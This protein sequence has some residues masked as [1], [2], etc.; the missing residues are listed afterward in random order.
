MKK[1]TNYTL[2]LFLLSLLPC[3]AFAQVQLFEDFEGPTKGGYAAASVEFKSGFWYL[4][5]ALLGRQH[6]DLSIGTQSVRIRNGSI[7]MEF[8]INGAGQVRFYQ[9]NANFSGDG[10]SR[11]QLQYSTDG[12]GSWDNIG[13][14]IICADDELELTVIDVDK[15]GD[16]RFKIFKSGGPSGNRIS[17]DNFEVTKYEPEIDE[18]RL[19]AEANGSI[20]ENNATL[21]YGVLFIDDSATKTITFSNTGKD[22]LIL[23][24]ALLTGDDVFEIDGTPPLE[25][26]E[27]EAKEFSVLFSPDRKGDFTA[28]LTLE[29]NDPAAEN[30]EINFSGR[31]VPPGVP[32]DIADARSFPQETIVTVSGWVT[33]ADEFHGPVYF[34]DETAGLA[35]FYEPLMR[36]ENEGF[37]LD[38]SH[39]DSI[40]VTG[41]LTNF[42][43]LLQ[44]APVEDVMET[45]DFQVYPDANRKIE[46]K[47][48]TIEQL[49]SGAYEGQLVRL[50]SITVEEG[51]AFEGETNYDISDGINESEL[52]VSVFT[53]IPG[54]NI[55]GQPIHLVGIAS[56]FQDFHQILP[57]SRADLIQTADAP[58]ITSASPYETAATATTISFAWETDVPGT[59][60]IC[61]GETEQLELGCKED[62][63]FKTNHSME[64]VDLDPATIYQVQLRTT[65]GA[66]T[67]FT[68][69]YYVT[70][71]SPP[72]T[73][74]EINVY[75]NQDVDHS[76]A[77]DEKA[78]QNINFSDQYIRRFFQAQ[79]SIDVA[80]YSISGDV[81]I[82]IANFLSQAHQRGLQ[83]RVILGHDRAT[84]TV[85][86]ELE[87]NGVPVIE[88]DFGDINVDRQTNQQNSGIQHNKFAVVDY[89]GGNPD[90]VWTIT[91]SWNATDMGT[92]VHHQNMIEIQDVALAGAYTREFD[93]MW[94]S[95][96]TT[97]DPAKARFGSHKR[98]VNPSLFWIGDSHIRLHFSPQGR[99]ESGIIQAINEAEHS[100]NIGTML[101][102]RFTIE[103]ALRNQHDAGL[104]IR[105][106]MSDVTGTGSQFENLS[107]WGDF[108]HFPESQFGLLHHKYAI[109]DGERSDWNGTVIT[110]SHNWSRAANESNDENT[111]IIQDSR[112][113]NLYIQEFGAR[114]TQAGGENTIIV[115][116]ETGYHDLPGTIRL[117]QNY[118]NP[119]NPATT[120]SFELPAAHLVDFKIY[121]VLGQEIA[122]LLNDQS[123]EA[124]T[125]HIDFDASSL[126]SGVYIYRIELDNGKS[127]SRKM[128]LIK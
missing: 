83:V 49:K 91:S 64:L 59:S 2:A 9:A 40:V 6:G 11:L 116:A 24:P 121:D 108:I 90:Q 128:T 107:S 68:T 50:D 43:N 104:T 60:E 122:V 89:K 99:T 37:L 3:T 86:N 124:G 7:A 46:P 80:F 47:T 110:G 111:L 73:T 81:G 119:F 31:A 57:R 70:T 29:T 19:R 18:P 117:H 114:Y 95:K 48:I 13:D 66:D 98:I 123:L 23:S 39:G 61:F 22:T 93:Q 44:I 38:V 28:T 76:L 97:P 87:N 113:A 69:P 58:V 126:S 96:T 36:N 42:Y 35:A 118:P 26:I 56:R 12:G 5:D 45:V 74:Q 106:L 1:I 94:G 71:N 100:I 127:L 77:L 21:D 125:H 14:E 52:R 79:H 25:I 17:I 101:I 10:N 67:S 78:D 103:R 27:G 85:R 41:A 102:T 72:G 53:D 109:I 15:E 30:F 32:I 88:S 51:G 120:L 55:P 8:D 4:D 115:R 112:I 82:Q 34:Q 33:V 92:N 63:E 65:A 54:L 62:A 75:F 16:I 20:I 84:D 105:G